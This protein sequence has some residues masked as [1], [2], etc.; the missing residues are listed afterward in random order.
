MLRDRHPS[1]SRWGDAAI[2][3]VA[4][5]NSTKATLTFDE[6]FELPYFAAFHLLEEARGRSALRE[7]YAR[8][9]EI[10]RPEGVAFILESPTWRASADWGQKLGY[11]DASLAKCRAQNRI[12]SIRCRHSSN[13]KLD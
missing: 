4:A 1:W 13:E 8:Y 9:A 10:A 5:R 3:H 11:S 7:Y 2:C 12:G 6:G